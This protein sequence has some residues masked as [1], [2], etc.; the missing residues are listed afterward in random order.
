MRTDK[1]NALSTATIAFVTIIG[2]MVGFYYNLKESNTGSINI[3]ILE[4][5]FVISIYL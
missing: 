3:I 5:L 1:L 4:S 2:L